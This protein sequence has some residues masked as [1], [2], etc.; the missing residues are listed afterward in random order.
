[1][2]LHDLRKI[3]YL[4]PARNGNLT[5]R[6]TLKSADQLQYRRFSRTILSHKA[7][8]VTLADMKIDLI[9]QGEAPIS[10]GKIVNRYHILFSA[11]QNAEFI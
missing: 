8:L 5:T 9:Q 2:M 1:M 11:Q 7:Y 10:Y 4:Q 6:R 3:T